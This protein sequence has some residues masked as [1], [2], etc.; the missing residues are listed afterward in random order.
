MAR[1]DRGAAHGNGGQETKL[2]AAG[3][4]GHLLRL[5]GDN[6][7][8]HLSDMRLHRS[9]WVLISL[10]IQY[11]PEVRVKRFDRRR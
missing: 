4:T 11:H 10:R 8:A 7:S 5:V 9:V 1:G 3:E 6:F 2:C